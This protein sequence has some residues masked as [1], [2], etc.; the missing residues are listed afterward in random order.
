[1]PLIL[2]ERTPRWAAAFRRE[3]RKA[4]KRRQTIPIHEV[5]SPAQC[6]RELEAAPHSIVAL[7]ILPQNLVSTTKALS[8]W[9]GRYANARFIA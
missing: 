5:R 6:Q 3:M 2:L 8:D 4:A 7:E 1:M 9:S